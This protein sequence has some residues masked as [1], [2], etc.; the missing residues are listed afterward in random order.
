MPKMVSITL[1][2]GYHLL[3]RLRTARG[4]FLLANFERLGFL[5]R[6]QIDLF[7][8]RFFS[9]LTIQLINCALILRRTRY[10]EKIGWSCWLKMW[11][12]K[13]PNTIMV[14]RFVRFIIVNYI[15]FFP[16]FIYFIN[17][18][19]TSFKICH[20]ITLTAKILCNSFRGPIFCP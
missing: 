20:N 11:C 15:E 9:W 4:L 13:G 17:F 6:L 19:S 2:Y 7:R 3:A 16:I 18:K 5:R 1:M 14:S 10:T 12:T 8:W